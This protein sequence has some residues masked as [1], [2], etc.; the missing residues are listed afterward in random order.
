MVETEL[1]WR[2]NIERSAASYLAPFRSEIVKQAMCRSDWS[3]AEIGDVNAKRQTTVYLTTEGSQAG[4]LRPI[5][6]AVV[7]QIVCLRVAVDRVAPERSCA[8]LMVLVND[9]SSLG[10]MRLVESAQALMPHG[11]TALILN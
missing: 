10:R 7:S 5:M 8:K 6:R 2:E 4:R 1:R 11:G 9:A 3:V